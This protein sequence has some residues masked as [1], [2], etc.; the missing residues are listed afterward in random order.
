[1]ND[2]PESTTN[3]SPVPQ[4]SGIRQYVDALKSYLTESGIKIKETCSET[5]FPEG[6]DGLG[7]RHYFTLRQNGSLKERVLGKNGGSLTE[8]VLGR[9]LAKIE[10]FDKHPLGIGMHMYVHPDYFLLMQAAANV[11]TEKTGLVLKLR[12]DSG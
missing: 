3:L 1:M 10:Y 5:S 12:R 9:V 4:S 6:M 2:Q 7:Q 11:A 8:R